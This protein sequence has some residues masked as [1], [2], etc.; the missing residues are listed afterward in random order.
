MTKHNMPFE[1]AVII[2]PECGKPKKRVTGD[3]LFNFDNRYIC[4][5]SGLEQFTECECGI[6]LDD[7]TKK[8]LNSI[9]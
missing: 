3:R 4:V 1:D 8:L 7:S 2:C 5:V 9:I 6:D